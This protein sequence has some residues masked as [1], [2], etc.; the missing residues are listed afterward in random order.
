MPLKYSSTSQLLSQYLSL[1]PS[2]THKKN[3]K[4]TTQKPSHKI[5]S[6]S[7]ERIVICLVC[8][9]KT[10][11]AQEPQVFLVDSQAGGEHAFGK[12]RADRPVISLLRCEI[13]LGW[14]S[15]LFWWCWPQQ[16]PLLTSSQSQGFGLP[17]NASGPSLPCEIFLARK[18]H[19]NCVYAVRDVR[20]ALLKYKA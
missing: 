18:L 14:A 4:P 1:W 15:G 3:P 12:A 16:L 19:L 13:G 10:S 6:R 11:C 17:S 8:I 9:L 5:A 2:D 20:L 7:T